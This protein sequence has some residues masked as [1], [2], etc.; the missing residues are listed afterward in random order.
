[1]K[2]SSTRRSAT[3]GLRTDQAVDDALVSEVD[4][5]GGPAVVRFCGTLFVRRDINMLGRYFFQLPDLPGGL[6]P[7]RDKGATDEE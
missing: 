6:R 1:M 4:R 2:T 3:R 7:L 5:A